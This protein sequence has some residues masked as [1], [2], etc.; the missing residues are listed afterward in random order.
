MPQSIVITVPHNLG[1]DAAKQ[2][3]AERIEL[4]RTTYVDKLAK[5]DIVW[6][7][8]RADLRVDALG[9]SMSAQIDVMPD[10]VRIEA[11]LPWLLAALGNKAKGFLT[12]N[13]KE[14][15]QIGYTPPK[16]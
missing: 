2:R 5:S 4:L 14:S 12:A 15:L 9:Q 6:T 16:V 7:G 11:Q 8:N 1:A 13:A 3:I 10:S